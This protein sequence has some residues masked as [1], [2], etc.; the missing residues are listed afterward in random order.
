M[1][2]LIEL[3]ITKRHHAIEKFASFEIKKEE[4][5]MLYGGVRE[6]KSPIYESDIPSNKSFKTAELLIDINQPNK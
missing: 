6:Y 5:D 1:K 2:K 4:S 3:L